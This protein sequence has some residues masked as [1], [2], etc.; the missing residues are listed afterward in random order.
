MKKILCLVL[1]ICM[2][3]GVAGCSFQNY[4]GKWLN[5]DAQYGY[6]LSELM[7]RTT[8]EKGGNVS[9]I[10]SKTNPYFPISYYYILEDD[11]IVIY[12][13]GIS[14]SGGGYSASETEYDVLTLEKEDGKRVLVSEKSGAKYYFTEE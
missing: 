5:E 13:S 3:L 7:T 11:K 8:G 4:E 9:L 14:I 10:P 12:Q 6:E 2:T 1:A